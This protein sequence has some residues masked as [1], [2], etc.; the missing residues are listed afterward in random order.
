MVLVHGVGA[1]VPN[2]GRVTF[3]DASVTAEGAISGIRAS[4]F[5]TRRIHYNDGLVSVTTG[6]LASGDSSFTLTPSEN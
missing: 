4:Y 3:A 1:Q 6:N 5:A 2:F